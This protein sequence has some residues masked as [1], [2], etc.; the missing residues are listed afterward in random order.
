MTAISVQNLRH[1]YGTLTAVADVSFEVPEGAIYGLIG[2]NGA[3][4]TTIIRSICTLIAPTSGDVQVLGFSIRREPL[5][6]RLV[7]A[8]MPENFGLYDEL[9]LWE[10]LD[11]FGRCYGISPSTRS[12]TIADVLELVDLT[13]KRNSYVA[14]LSRGM[15][16]RL[17]LARTLLHDPAV[18]VLDEPSAGLD[19]RARIELRELLREL[20]AMNKTIVLSSHILSD[21][22]E[23]CSHIAILDRGKLVV[24]GPLEE[25]LTRVRGGRVVIV[26]VLDDL[27]N[28]VAVTQALPFVHDVTKLGPESQRPAMRCIVTGGDQDLV[29]LLARLVASE[30]SVATFREERSDLEDVFMQSTEPT[31][32]H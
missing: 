13:G 27:D 1:D 22:A 23:I 3:G 5:A 28:A 7:L 29:T 15:R 4:K 11:F 25:V 18:L 10:Y 30:I 26:E 32:P 31:L 8:Y 6:I 14:G 2:P 20:R 9:R 12:T 19:P 17:A 16:Q 24:D 21:L